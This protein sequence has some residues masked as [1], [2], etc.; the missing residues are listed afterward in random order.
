[1]QTALAPRRLFKC[2]NTTGLVDLANSS[3]VSQ[4]RN[5]ELISTAGAICRHG[6]LFQAYRGAN[7]GLHVKK[8]LS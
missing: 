7:C 1:M 4:D 6:Y 3:K 8:F 5:N 2:S